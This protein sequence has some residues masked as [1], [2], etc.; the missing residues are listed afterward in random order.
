MAYIEIIDGLRTLKLHGM[1]DAFIELS[2]QAGFSQMTKEVVVEEL[3]KAELSDR[4]TRSIN[5]QMGIAKFPVPRNLDGFNFTESEV[6]EEQIRGLYEGHFVDDKRNII[7]V[8]GTGTGKS[9]LAIAISSQAV[10]NGLK[11]RFFNV[12][13]LVNQLEQEKMAGRAGYLAQRLR[14]V[15][16]VVLDELGYLPFSQ[17]G[18]ALLFHLISQLYEKVSLIVTTNLSFGEWTQVFVDKK[19][20][21][22]ML[23]RVTHH[24]DIIETGNDSYRFKTR[25]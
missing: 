14:C 18:G 20:T 1:A 9:H 24:C 7:L 25:N 10:R 21:T 11:A 15:D 4:K 3:T 8:G 6:K 5:Y 12:V 13:D 22:A 2:Q 23:D 16:V 17:A 19:M